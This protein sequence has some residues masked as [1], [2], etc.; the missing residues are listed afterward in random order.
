MLQQK[1]TTKSVEP[2]V[3]VFSDVLQTLPSDKMTLSEFE[4]RV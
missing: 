2:E 1:N 4:I 3:T